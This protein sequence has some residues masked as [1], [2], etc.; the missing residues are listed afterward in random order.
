MEARVIEKI[1]KAFEEGNV[2]SVEF[3]KDGSG[4]GFV[5]KDPTGDHGMPCRMFQSVR[6][7]IAM[8]IIA[9]YRMK[10]HEIRRCG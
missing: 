6:I 1:R 9:G 8:Q 10:Q 5:Y 3:H 2:I 4:V 7:D